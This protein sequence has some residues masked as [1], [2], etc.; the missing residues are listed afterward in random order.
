MHAHLS[1]KKQFSQLWG[2]ESQPER[3]RCRKLWKP[4]QSVFI[5]KKQLAG[6]IMLLQ[7]VELFL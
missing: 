5:L 3:Y 6:N 7:Y 1:Y 2:F 4:Q